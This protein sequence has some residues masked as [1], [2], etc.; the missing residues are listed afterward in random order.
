MKILKAL[1]GI[2]APRIPT[3]QAQTSQPVISTTQPQSRANLEA[4]HRR[5]AINSSNL[6][7]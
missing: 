4:L 6:A 7:A 1:S 3:T 2:Q 5:P